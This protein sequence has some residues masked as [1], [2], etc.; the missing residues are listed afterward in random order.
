VN[1]PAVISSPR[2]ILLPAIAAALLLSAPG[3]A[4]AA[5]PQPRASL[6]EIESQVMCPICGTLLELSQSPQAERE[7]VFIRR[8]IA[9]GKT[10][11]QI[12]D[13]LVA[14]YGPDV[15]A[16]PRA[17]GFDLSAYLV[18]IIAFLVAIAALVVGVLRWRR[19]SSAASE[20]ESPGPQG[21]DADR[22]DEDLA[23]YDL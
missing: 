7:R 5:D 20:S 19:G 21:E 15:L 3:V 10:T 23:R 1:R 9:R 6:P 13:A 12:K 18:P 16:L 14:E 2:S 17:S 11:Q 8:L 4:A 22:L